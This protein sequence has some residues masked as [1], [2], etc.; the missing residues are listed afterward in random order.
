[1]AIYKFEDFR[2]RID[3]T[4][5]VHDSATV[6]GDCEL[7]ANSSVW[8]GAVVRADNDSV[9]IGPGVNIQDGAVVHV[10]S[11]HPVVLHAGVTI[12]HQA[13]IHGCTIGENTLVGMQSVVMNDAVVGKNCIIGAN[14]VVTAGTVIPDGSLVIGTPGRVLRSTTADEIANNEKNALGYITKAKIYKTTQTRIDR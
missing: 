5:Y 12:A 1:M 9:R 4:A 8:P 11:G 13:M 2:P 7:E 3:P 14:T 10:D 6:I